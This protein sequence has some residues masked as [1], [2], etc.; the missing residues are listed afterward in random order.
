MNTAGK[1][2]AKTP[3]EA[4][5]ADGTV[6]P[7]GEPRPPGR[8][9]GSKNKRTLLGNEFLCT[10]GPR[11]KKRLRTIIDG[12]DDELALKAIELTLAYN[13]GR[14]VQAKEISGPDG[15]PIQTAHARTVIR[16]DRELAR[17]ITLALDGAVPAEIEATVIEPVEPPVL[18]NGALDAAESS[19]NTPEGEKATGGESEVV[20]EPAEPRV[21]FPPRS[22]QRPSAPQLPRVQRGRENRRHGR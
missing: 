20:D 16:D 13:F 10:L 11:A 3:V 19:D 9:K 12:D 4:R 2:Q 6:V 8:P 5:L 18:T 17:R 15:D 1:S 14:P 7:F 21:L 22:D